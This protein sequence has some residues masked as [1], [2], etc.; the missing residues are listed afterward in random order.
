MNDNYTDEEVA[1]LNRPPPLDGHKQCS[2]C[3]S[4]KPETEFYRYAHTTACKICEAVRIK[5]RRIKNPTLERGYRI[6][7]RYGLSLEDW[8]VLFESQGSVCALCQS[9]DP[10]FK[11]GWH[12]D[13]DPVTQ[14][15]RGIL[16]YPCNRKLGTYEQMKNN[17]TV[18]AYLNK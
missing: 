2:K 10:H 14:K 8:R 16:C 6:K 11:G 13:H 5:D 15:V 17:T 9:S 12:T 4:W 7:S 1:L 18:Q 3:F